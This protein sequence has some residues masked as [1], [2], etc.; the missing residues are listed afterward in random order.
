[1]T[2]KKFVS[3]KTNKITPN[4]VLTHSQ[5]GQTCDNSGKAGNGQSSRAAM[6]RVHTG[7]AVTSPPSRTR[8]SLQENRVVSGSSTPDSSTIY[9]LQLLIASHKQFRGGSGGQSPQF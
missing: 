4:R 2:T 5:S 9:A 7:L 8:V 3:T 6:D 1:M